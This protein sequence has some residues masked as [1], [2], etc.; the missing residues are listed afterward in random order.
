ML[1]PAVTAWSVPGS[2]RRYAQCAR[3]MGIAE[4]GEPDDDAA[5][6][7]VAALRAK[8]VELDVPTPHRYGLDP[9]RWTSLLPLM[10]EQAIASGSPANNP[11]VPDAGE[12]VQ[13]YRQVWGQA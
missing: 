6:A 8:N 13:L 2:E 5:H 7:L 10:A 1:L 11:R 12:V 3:T 4:A 9:D